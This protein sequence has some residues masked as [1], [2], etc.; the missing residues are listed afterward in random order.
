MSAELA[1]LVANIAPEGLQINIWP[2]E[3]GYQANVKERAAKGWTCT[4]DPCPV[5][6]LLMA[7][8][9]RNARHPARVVVS[10]EEAGQI[11]I[12]EAIATATTV[13]AAGDCDHGI[14]G[15]LRCGA[16]EETDLAEFGL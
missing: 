2:T 12:E 16:C 10:S 4:S 15:H 8:R 13:G 7:M 9:M 3:R 5:T 6:A 14:P 1:H 11:D